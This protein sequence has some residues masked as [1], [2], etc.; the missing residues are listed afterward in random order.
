MIDTNSIPV[1]KYLYYDL[2]LGYVVVI[3]I[4]Y[5]NFCR[6]PTALSYQGPVA[7]VPIPAETYATHHSYYPP[8]PPPIQHN[9]PPPPPPSGHYSATSTQR[10]FYYKR[11]LPIDS[12]FMK[13]MNNKKKKKSLSQ[14]IPQRKDWS[15]EDAKRAIELEKEY[16]RRNRSASLII[17]FPDTELNRDIVARFHP[18]IDTVHFQQPS[19]PR[20]C[21]VA[22]KV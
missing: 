10:S 18:S 20:F 19:T 16:N 8:P 9:P 22:L 2:F 14:N 17:K 21:F 1:Y 3:K 12:D 5:S 13:K 15:V 6:L 7:Y 4:L 11:K